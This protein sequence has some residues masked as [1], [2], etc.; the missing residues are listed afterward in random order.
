MA[1]LDV[2]NGLK[3]LDDFIDGL[4]ILSDDINEIAKGAIDQASP[5]LAQALSSEISAQANR[6][7]ATGELA[8]SVRPTKA[9]INNYGVF[10]AVIVSG[11]DDRGMRNGEK[12][13]Y[14][15]YGTSKQAAH[16]V[17]QSAISKSEGRCTDI[18]Q[19]H[20]EEKVSKLTD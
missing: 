5:T 11:T 2:S 14:L 20:F 18:I 13:A 3:N 10:C 12:L 8:G 17:M 19:K 6:G 9:K 4:G 16:P 7:Y 1:R 15:E